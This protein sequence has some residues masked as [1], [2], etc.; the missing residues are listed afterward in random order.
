MGVRY[1]L[2]ITGTCS[3]ALGH[4][5]FVYPHV[6]PVSFFSALGGVAMFSGA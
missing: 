2:A 3:P 5:R 4:Q 1:F 6:A